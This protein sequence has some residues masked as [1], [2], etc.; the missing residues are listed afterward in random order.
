MFFATMFDTRSFLQ[1]GPWFMSEAPVSPDPGRGEDPPG[2]PPGPGDLPWLGSPDWTLVPD[3][4]DWPDW[5]GD[6]AFLDDEYPGDLGDCQD[7][8]S[9]P[10]AGLGDARLAALIAGARQVTADRA[11]A[12]RAAARAGSTGAVAAAVAVA[13]GRR[14]P[15]MPGSARTFP[16]EYAGRAAGLASGRPLD[17]APGCLVLGQ[18]AGD[19]AGGDDRYAGALDDELPGVICA[20]DRVGAHVC[21]RQHAAVAELVR[22]ANAY[23]VMWSWMRVVRPA[24]PACQA[25]MGNEPSDSMR[26]VCVSW[27]PGSPSR[28]CARLGDCSS[29]VRRRCG[30]PR[31]GALCSRHLC[32]ARSSAACAI[33]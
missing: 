3:R 6:E 20:W 2:T 24:G 1:N 29:P 5:H 31:A 33:P 4:P 14:G 21:A 28:C 22:R 26:R 8:D 10:P 18:S 16:G 15:G 12:A 7:P 19:A 13:V 11:R 9:A 23:R 30:G 27:R 32:P 25:R 17:A